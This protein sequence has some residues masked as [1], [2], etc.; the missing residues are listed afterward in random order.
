[1][2]NSMLVKVFGNWLVALITSQSEAIIIQI[3][4]L[5]FLPIDLHRSYMDFHLEDREKSCFHIIT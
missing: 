5:Q 2:L 1:M 3:V 4:G